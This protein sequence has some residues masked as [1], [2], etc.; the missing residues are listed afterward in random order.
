LTDYPLI[1]ATIFAGLGIV[2]FAVAL[3]VISRLAPFRL[4]DEIKDRNVAVATVAAAVALGVA[5]IVAA[6]MH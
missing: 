5:I 6:T 3:A 4:W 1:N 2:V